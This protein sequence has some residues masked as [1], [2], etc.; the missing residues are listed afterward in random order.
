MLTILRRI[1]VK[2]RKLEQIVTIVEQ[3][4][5]DYV[6][7]YRRIGFSDQ[8]KQ[9]II[10]SIVAILPLIVDAADGKVPV[11]AAGGL[12]DKRTVRAAFDLGAE[13]VYAGTAFLATEESPLAENIKQDMLKYDADDLLMFRAPNSFYQSLPGELPEKLLEM[14]K[15]GKSAAEIWAAAGD[16]N[17]LL[18]GMHDGDLSRGI[19]SFGLGISSIHSIDPVSVVVDRLN[20]GVIA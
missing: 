20:S 6:A 5:A 4:L 18:Y 16:Y 13:G 8:E 2:N 10:N 17:C 14:D 11:V 9:N 15:Q 12:V 1:H 19:A 3:V 7:L